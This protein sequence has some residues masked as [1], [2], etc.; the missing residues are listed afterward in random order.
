MLS[1]EGKEYKTRWFIPKYKYSRHNKGE[2]IIMGEICR[3]QNKTIK[4][5]SGEKVKPVWEKSLRKAKNEM[6]T[7]N[8]KSYGITRWR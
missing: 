5:K 7:C 1:R 6:G 2:K 4:L 8:E 3:S